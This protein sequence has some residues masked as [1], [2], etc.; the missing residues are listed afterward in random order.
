MIFRPYPPK[1]LEQISV[2]C[3]DTTGNRRKIIGIRRSMVGICQ[4][5]SRDF[6]IEILLP[7]SV[8]F[9]DVFLQEPA[10]IF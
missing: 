10:G 2:L 7:F 4:E 9:S 3:K 6:P 1:T 8:C 5:K